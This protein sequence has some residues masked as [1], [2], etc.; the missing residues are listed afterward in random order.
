[1][2]YVLPIIALLFSAPLAAADDDS[3]DV[4]AVSEVDAINCWLDQPTYL[5][6]VMA[7]SEEDGLA[8]SRGWRKVE[9][10]NPF[11]LEYELPAPITIKGKYQTRHIAFV[12][13]GIV[14]ILDLPD[15]EVIARDEG[16]ANRAET[17][18]PIAEILAS[19]KATRA[20]ID[21]RMGIR[22]FLGQRIVSDITSPAANG[23]SFGTRTVIAVNISNV[24]SHPDKTLYGCSY[25]VEPID[26]DGKPM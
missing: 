3:I 8:S 13:R 4:A 18:T 21:A 11:L 2:R 14:A 26:K 15:P 25:E 10:R 22:K 19:G 6:F 12:A 20:D 23:E 16:I 1:M 5:A 24:T 17:I 7:V 9:G